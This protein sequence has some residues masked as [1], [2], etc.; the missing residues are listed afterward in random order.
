MMVRAEAQ[1]RHIDTRSTDLEVDHPEVLTKKESTVSLLEDM[2]EAG[3]HTKNIENQEDT[4][5]RHIEIITEG[6]EDILRH[7]L[8]IHRTEKMTHSWNLIIRY[9]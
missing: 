8:D 5:D 4:A 1:G 6:P 3:H 9:V 2:V 7:H